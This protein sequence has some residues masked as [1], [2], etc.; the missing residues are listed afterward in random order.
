[1]FRG[2]FLAIAGA[3]MWGIQGPVAQFLFQDTK[4]STTWLMG[5]KMLLAGVGLLL[6]AKYG[7]HQSLRTIWQRPQNAGQLLLYAVLGLCGVQYFFLLTVQ[8]SNSATATIMQSLGTVVIVIITIIVTK[9]APTSLEGLAVVVAL[10]GAWLLVT[11]GNLTVLAISPKTLWLGL[12]V[13]VA[14]ALQTL[15]PVRL[16]QH[17]STVMVVGWAMLL[18]GILFTVIHPFWVQVPRLTLAGWLGVAFIVVFGTMLSFLCFI[19]SL[20]YISPTTAGLLDTFEPLSAT[21]GTVWFFQTSFN[22]YEVMG[23]GLIL[24]TVFILALQTRF[25]NNQ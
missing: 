1:M 12:A 24:S 9:K 2:A 22:M 10:L 21:I 5:I 6:L 16:I 11:K 25:P 19:S 23:A 18:G 20:H 15:L 13:A 4:F 3:L 8:A 7:L 14:G 17:F